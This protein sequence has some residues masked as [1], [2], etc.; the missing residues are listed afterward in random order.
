MYNA[1][2]HQG[3]ISY[4]EQQTALSITKLPKILW[5]CK[6]SRCIGSL[7]VSTLVAALTVSDMAFQGSTEQPKYLCICPGFESALVFRATT[8]S[9]QSGIPPKTPCSALATAPTTHHPDRSAPIISNALLVLQRTCMPAHYCVSH[10]GHCVKHLCLYR[11]SVAT[12]T[13]HPR[14]VNTRPSTQGSPSKLP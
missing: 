3:S 11:M 14:A 8:Q 5:Y 7:P 12:N 13:R 10:P 4:A 6:H 9:G 1:S 2:L